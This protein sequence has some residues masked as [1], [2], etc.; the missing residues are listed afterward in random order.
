[1][2]LTSIYY[3]DTGTC[4]K[5]ANSVDPAQMPDQRFFDGDTWHLFAECQTQIDKL[6]V[7]KWQITYK[8]VYINDYCLMS[9]WIKSRRKLN[10]KISSDVN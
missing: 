5:Y 3:S 1:M 9:F 4:I 6:Q 7:P 10:S 2:N 8:F